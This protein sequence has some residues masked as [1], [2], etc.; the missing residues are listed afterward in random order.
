[1]ISVSQMISLTP[2]T[3]F[4]IDVQPVNSEKSI[5]LKYLLIQSIFALPS[6]SSFEL[7]NKHGDDDDDVMQMPRVF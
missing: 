2:K 5:H 3:S 7:L 4:K 1:M 6:V